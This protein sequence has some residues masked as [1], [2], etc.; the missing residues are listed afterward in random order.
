[1]NNGMSIHKFIHKQ[2]RPPATAVTWIPHA[3]LA[4]PPKQSN[5]RWD[6]LTQQSLTINPKSTIFYRLALVLNFLEES[7]RFR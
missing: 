1:M 5:R 7:V 2:E 4:N 6:I 3:H